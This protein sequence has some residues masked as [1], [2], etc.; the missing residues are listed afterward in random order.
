K[1]TAKL[2]SQLRD[3]MTAASHASQ[4]L[5]AIIIP[6]S[7]AHQSEYLAECDLRRA[8][9]SGFTG[10][11]GT[12]VVTQNQAALWTDGRYFLQAEKELDSNWNLMKMG[13]KE[14]PSIEDWLC[15]VLPT[16]SYVGVNPFLY[17]ENSWNK[18]KCALEK[19]GH[20]LLETKKDLVDE[21]WANRP[22]YPCTDLMVVDQD[23]AGATCMEKITDIRQKMNDKKVKWMVVTALDEIAWLFNLRA[24]DIQYN[25][26]FFAY[27]V[28]GSESVHLFINQSRIKDNIASHLTD[29][30][31]L[32]CYD[33]IIS[34]L[35]QTCSSEKVWLS[36]N[37][38]HAIVSSIYEKHRHVTL[39]SLVSMTKCFKNESEINGMLKANIQDAVAL[40][41]F[42]HWMEQEVPK[43]TVTECSA[44]AKSLEFR[45]Q[46]EGFVSLSFGTISS[47]GSTGSII[48]YSP[49]PE[50]DRV[51]DV[52]EVYLCD[53]GAQYRS[54]TTD[55]TRTVHFSQPCQYV[56]ECFTRVLKGH[57]GIASIIFPAGTKGYWLDTLARMHLWKV[58]LDYR[59]GT[60]HGVGSFLNVHEGKKKLVVTVASDVELK[61]GLIITDEPGYYEDGKFGIRIE[62]ALLCKTAE[63]PYQFGGKQFLKF[64]SIALVPIQAKMIDVSLLSIEE[65]LWLNDYHKKCLD[66]IG[67]EL[68]KGGHNDTYDWLV[69]QTKSL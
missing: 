52:N 65:L 33:D 25:P 61:P 23:V 51:I 63:T 67:P 40:C 60:G 6:S 34:F 28:I 4:P 18:M 10:S 15:S 29:S 62:N 54:G 24:S 50:A 16:C 3:V 1:D 64:E 45:Q 55:T 41:R 21:V 30:V 7:D 35:E 2:L 46:E 26:V 69:E 12:A 44:A 39:N 57:I 49:N 47:S 27:A 42:F 20:K 22:S 68:K 31:A 48:H 9:I 11:A 36:S 13:M 56:K 66:V 32:H 8:F 59:H 17:P 43:A 38:S 37:S 53:S 5:Q 58:G 14:T 19:H